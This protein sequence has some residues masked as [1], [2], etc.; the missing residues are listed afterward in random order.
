M[1]ADK[2]T[3]LFSGIHW[4]HFSNSR[5]TRPAELNRTV[6]VSPGARSEKESTWTIQVLRSWRG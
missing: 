1:K 6:P 4:H 2:S 3:Q 5:A